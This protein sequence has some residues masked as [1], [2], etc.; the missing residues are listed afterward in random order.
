[1]S[2][3]ALADALNTLEIL[4][5]QHRLTRGR[6]DLPV[7]H[8]EQL[9]AQIAETMKLAMASLKEVVSDQASGN[10]DEA[11]RKE[12]EGIEGDGP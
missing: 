10:L 2:L 1:M 5:K 11:I 12:D 4:L 7:G 8:F 9:D 6:D 3:R